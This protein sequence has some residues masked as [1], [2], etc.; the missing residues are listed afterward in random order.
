MGERDDVDRGKELPTPT[1]EGNNMIRGEK[2]FEEKVTVE[3]DLSEIQDGLPTDLIKNSNT[4]DGVVSDHISE[5]EKEA[6]G[7]QTRLS[8]GKGLIERSGMININQVPPSETHGKPN[9]PTAPPFLR[10]SSQ[11]TRAGV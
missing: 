11:R 2:G 10:R 7:V 5:W 6:G 1:T 3:T 8:M 9:R 4:T